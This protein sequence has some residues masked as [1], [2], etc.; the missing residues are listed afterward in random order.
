MTKDYEKEDE[1]LKETEY[2]VH[3]ITQTSAG[4]EEKELMVDGAKVVFRSSLIEMMSQ[5]DFDDLISELIKQIGTLFE[6]RGNPTVFVT[7]FARC[8]ETG[9]FTIKYTDTYE[10]VS[11]MCLSILN[12]R[13][14][15]ER[16]AGGSSVN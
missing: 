15:C 6:L 14:Q 10:A 8:V 7:L 5:T 11:N 3:A 16:S 1:I 4:E 13:A 12:Q 9:L 2:S